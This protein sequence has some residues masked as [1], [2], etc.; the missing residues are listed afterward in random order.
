M[1]IH[2]VELTSEKTDEQRDIK[3]KQKQ[4]RHTDYIYSHADIQIYYNKRALTDLRKYTS[5]AQAGHLDIVCVQQNII[6]KN[7]HLSLSGWQRF[8]N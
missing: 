6:N 7:Q 4:G 2:V 5:I 1:D 3:T 8:L